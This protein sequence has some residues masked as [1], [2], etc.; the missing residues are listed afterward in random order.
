M[1]FTPVAAAA[2]AGLLADACLAA[3]DGEHPVRV[4]L[5][6]PQSS[7]LLELAGKTGSLLTA[8]GRRVGIVD[9][10]QFYRDASV[11]LEY[12]H[13]DVE[14]FFSGWLDL[15]ALDREVLTPLGRPIDGAD[16]HWHYLPSLRDPDSNRATR[17]E[18]ITL[19]RTSVVL[20][21]GEL[22]LGRGLP[23]DLT[24]HFWVSRQARRRQFPA[25]RQWTLPAF[26]RYE[27]L[28][29]PVAEADLVVRYDDAN[30]PARSV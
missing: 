8:A 1:K 19:E 26:D 10:S 3:D 11:R 21:V 7:A 25:E 23:A 24:V 22:L 2:L 13:T 20:V 28:L 17:A 6:G 12:G 30:R 27:Q 5:D 16:A 14:S 9:A 4:L 29:A 18:P 15:A